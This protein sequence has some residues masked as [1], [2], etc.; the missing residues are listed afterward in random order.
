MDNIIDA[1]PEI[2]LISPCGYGAE[3]A[4]DEYR[5]MAFPEEWNAIPAVRNGRVYALEA[6]GYYS[7]PGPRLVIGIEALAKLFHPAVEV[8]LEAEAAV[9]HIS[10]GTNSARAA[11]V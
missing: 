11:S 5:D 6:N 1:A 2:L 9:L 4:R 7:R 8:S 10:T 3:Q